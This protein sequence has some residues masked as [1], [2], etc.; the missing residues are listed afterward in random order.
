[1][2]KGTHL[3]ELEELALLAVL[4]LREDAYGGTVRDEL[5][6]RADRRVSIST[7]YVTLLRLEEKG[8]ARSRLGEP[9]EKRGGK[10]K[11]L[12]EVTPEGVAALEAARDVRERLWTA[13]EG[14][15]AHAR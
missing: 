2:A 3:G 6:R 14:R 11:R 8:Y 13:V 9:G 12:Y 1:M 15:R 5:E 7:V 10:A 4:G